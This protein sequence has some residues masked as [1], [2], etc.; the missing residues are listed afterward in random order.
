MMPD[1]TPLCA[2]DI[3][4]YDPLHVQFVQHSVY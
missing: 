4:H 3:L 2:G 1:R